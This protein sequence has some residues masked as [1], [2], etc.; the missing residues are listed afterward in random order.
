MDLRAITDLEGGRLQ[1]GK[2]FGPVGPAISHQFQVWRANL[3]NP[4]R[5]QSVVGPLL[6]R[7]S[8]RQWHIGLF[9]IRASLNPPFPGRLT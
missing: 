7:T 2:L 1:S 8:C 6:S 3:A 4:I 9:T 5:C